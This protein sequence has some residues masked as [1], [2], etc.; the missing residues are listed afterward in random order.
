MKRIIAVLNEPRTI[1]EY[2]VYAQ[3]VVERV[4]ADPI[5]VSP[6]PPI[7]VLRADVAA[8]RAA[9]VAGLTRTAGTRAARL[10]LAALVHGELTTL[11]CYVQEVA[12]EH[13]REEAPSIIARAGLSVKNARGPSKAW[14]EVKQLPLS[15][16]VHVWARAEK[17]RASYDWQ[18]SKD[19]Q[20]W[21]FGPR[22]VRADVKLYGLVRGT[23]YFFRYRTVTR[24]GV[25]DWS[26][27]VS[28][29]VV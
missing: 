21:L 8:L 4:A 23:V 26:Q 19:Q 12:D 16:A 14:F 17:G 13:P 24:E 20:Q 1:H 28:L 2:V 3:F 11:K 22:T 10:A 25:S 9:T 29:L 7:A 27:V 5:F 15:G 18:Y 6:R